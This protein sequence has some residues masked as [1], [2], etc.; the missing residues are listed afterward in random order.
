[1]GRPE[2]PFHVLSISPAFGQRVTRTDWFKIELV[3]QFLLRL[4]VYF[5]EDNC[6][7][8]VGNGLDAIAA[9]KNFRDEVALPISAR[10]LNGLE[11]FSHQRHE[12][13]RQGVT[14]VVANR[15]ADGSE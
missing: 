11:P 7:E 15:S 9:R 8:T 1:M 2:G 6:T 5:R 3:N 12:C 10:F 14:P 13:A 4:H